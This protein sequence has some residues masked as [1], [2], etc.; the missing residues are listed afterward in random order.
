MVFY[1]SPIASFIKALIVPIAITIIFC[2]LKDIKVAN[3]GSNGISYTGTSVSSLPDAIAA[4]SSQR[5]AV[6]TNGI[7]DAQLNK[8]IHSLLQEPGMEDFDLQ[9]HDDPQSLFSSCRQS[10]YGTSECFAAV[11]FTAFNDTNAEYTI[12][13]DEDFLQNTPYSY[14]PGES[15]LS[16]R[17]LPLQWALD[18]HIGGF[19]SSKRPAEKMWSGYFERDGSS[20]SSSLPHSV[21]WL[22]LVSSF[23]APLFI[24]IFLIATYHISSTVAGERQDSV[25]DLLVAQGVTTV[26]RVLSNI[27]SFSIL[28][29]PGVVISSIMLGEILFL[30]TSTG[31]IFILMLLAALA[32]IIC[33]HSIGSFFS[34]SSVSGMWACILIFALA[35]V[36]LSQSLTSFRDPGQMLGLSLVFP[37]YAFATLIRDIAT[38]EY[39]EEA[40]PSN[41]RTQSGVVMN[42]N[43]YLYFACFIVHIFLYGG[44]IFLVEH[45]RWGVPRTREWTETSDEVALKLSNL[46]KTYGKKKA[47]NDFN[48]EI[49]TGSVTFL[50]G[51]NGSGKTTT[52]KCISGVLKVDDGSKIQL[53]RDGLSFGLCPQ[54]NV[55]YLHKITCPTLTQ[56]FEGSMG[57]SKYPRTRA[58]LDRS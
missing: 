21:F 32:L 13:I 7:Q 24:F 41:T 3:E 8:T 38:A 16:K 18:S 22:T 4:S 52:L 55:R 45:L 11:V 19:A 23:V 29:L 5:L 31:L 20:Y 26:P 46:S 27:L 14:S 37:P 17:I 50:L 1:K 43:G 12:G 34:K 49:Q 42:M 57:G 48:A 9:L 33:A 36:S 15:V 58:P 40:F 39:G 6:V 10:I 44:L 53:S 47:V 35:L 51:P 56:R 25:V 54:N 2:F 28:Y 30:H